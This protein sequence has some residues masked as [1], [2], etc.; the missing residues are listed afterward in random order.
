M[1]LEGGVKTGLHNGTNYREVRKYAQANT[2]VM[3]YFVTRCYGEYMQSILDDFKL[4]PP[5]VIIMNSCLWDLHRYGKS[6]NAEYI[7]NISELLHAID[8]AVPYEDNLFIWNATLP[9]RE[10][11]KAGFLPPG[12]DHTLPAEDIRKANLYVRDQLNVYGERFIFLDLHQTFYKHLDLRVKDGV[13]WNDFAHR[14]ITCLILSEISKHWNFEIPSFSPAHDEV[15]PVSSDRSMNTVSRPSSAYPR[16]LFDV[17]PPPR[18]DD[19]E[20]GVMDG[21]SRN[22]S[23]LRMNGF[24]G[25]FP[26]GIPGPRLSRPPGPRYNILGPRVRSPTR[27]RVNGPS[28]PTAAS[29]RHPGA[30]VI[31]PG[32]P[33]INGPSGLRTSAVG[34]RGNSPPGPRAT[35]P[36]PRASPPGIRL[37]GSPRTRMNGPVNSG[38]LGKNTI[39]NGA[40]R[41]GLLARNAPVRNRP[42][43]I[44]PAG[45]RNRRGRSRSATV[46]LVGPRPPPP[47][48]WLNGPPRFLNNN[49]YLPSRF[50]LNETFPPAFPGK[51]IF[52]EEDDYHRPYKFPRKFM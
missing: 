10:T 6:A 30:K 36:G 8:L 48:S 40:V 42:V 1:L 23:G 13:H 50:S 17:P 19:I 4:D 29:F 2:T 33:S 20:N 7:S 12:V 43:I 26:R 44:G 47:H 25:N 15:P 14:K 38:P 5:H 37:N 27:I 46:N 35:P 31:S 24:P 28:G 32:R 41:N 52:I 16:P 22:N 21:P 51:R 49:E 3:F 11:V 18:F 45:V 9:V 34:L 39:S